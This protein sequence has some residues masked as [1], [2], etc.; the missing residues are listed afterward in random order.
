MYLT[1]ELPW[2]ARRSRIEAAFF[3]EIIFKC[4]I[5]IFTIDIFTTYHYKCGHLFRKEGAVMKRVFIS[6][7]ILSV[8]LFGIEY[9][10]SVESPPYKTV[11]FFDDYRCEF[12]KGTGAYLDLD[13]GDTVQEYRDLGDYASTGTGRSNWHDQ[14]SCMVMGPGVSSV[15]VY[16]HANFG[17]KSKEFTKTAGNPMGCWS[18]YGDWWDNKISSIKIVPDPTVLPAPANNVVFFEDCRCDENLGSGY[19]IQLPKGQYPDLGTYNLGAPGTPNWHDKI[20]G[21]VMG[22]GITKVTVYEHANY[23]GRS[24]VFTRTSANTNKCTSLSGDW[25]DNKI[26]SIKIE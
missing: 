1:H 19:F 14:I 16:E 15:I 6:A 3:H 9:A 21:I 2:Q 8:V 5:Y 26:S 11:R 4:N 23:G 7:L 12:T 22:T 13:V 10:G 18:L 17:G 20:S 25:W 24:K